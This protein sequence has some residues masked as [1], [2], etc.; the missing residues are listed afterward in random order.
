[1]DLLLASTSA[2]RGTL[3][4]NAG[5]PYA[6][7]A[8]RVDEREIERSHGGSAEHLAATL[9]QAKALSVSGM[10]PD[11][12]VIGA[13]STLEVEGRRFNK[14]AGRKEAA[15]HLRFFSGREMQ[16]TSA[17]AIAREGTVLW[18]AAETARLKLRVLSEPF[19]ARYLEEE[20]PDVGYCVGVF[21]LEGPG[22]Q[23]FERIDGDHFTV[24]GLPLLPLL[25]ALRELGVLPS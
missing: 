6:A 14:P 17:V 8:P 12:L 16:L 15:E 19:I 9:A 25:G 13:D 3:L 7:V 18:Q 11:A 22:V 4:A 1:M 21:R 5:V 2:I 24:L 23:L 20:W 10:R